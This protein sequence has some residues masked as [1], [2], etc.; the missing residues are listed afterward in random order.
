MPK[1]NKGRNIYFGS[2]FHSMVGWLHFWGPEAR[3][4]IM[5]GGW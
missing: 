2:W 1:K 4:D 5:A 3:L